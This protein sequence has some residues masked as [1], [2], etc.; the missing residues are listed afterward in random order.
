M[1]MVK[2]KGTHAIYKHSVTIAGHRTS[3]SLEAIFWDRLR[4][5]A[6]ARQISVNRLIQDIDRARAA[7][8]TPANLS[9]AV[10][11]FVLEY[12]ESAARSRK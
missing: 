2:L 3:L 7:N 8:A 6:A 10:R 12:L 1:T 4:T 5:M 11:V 9:S